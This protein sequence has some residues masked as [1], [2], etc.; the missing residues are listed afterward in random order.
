MLPPIAK[1]YLQAATPAPAA[2]LLINKM[3][4]TWQQ[5]RCCSALGAPDKQG[6]WQ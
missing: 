3:N 6:D 2:Y 5:L 1:E 4:R